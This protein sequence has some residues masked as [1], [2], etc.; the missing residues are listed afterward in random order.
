[1]NSAHPKPVEADPIRAH[2]EMLHDRAA[3]LNGVLVVSVFNAAL[4]KDAGVITH[5]KIGDVDGMVAA[6]KAH[7]D[8]PHMNI[9]C[10]CQVMRPDLGRGKRGK[11]SDVVAVLGL[12]A[13]MDNDTGK[14]AGE[15]PVAPNYVIETSPGNFQPFWLFDRPVKPDV[16]KAIALGLKAATGSDHGT[17]DIDHIWRIPG[18]LNWPNKKKLE[19]G[20]SPEPFT[21]A[22]AQPWDGALTDPA[23]M[24]LAVASRAPAS[25]ESKPATLGDLPSV[26]GIE[27]SA[28]A[29]AML[30]ADD[31]GDRSVHASSVVEQLAFD[32]HTAE[33]AA[34]LFLAATGNWLER[35]STEGAARTDF[36]RLW[37]KYGAHH[38]EERASAAAFAER[39]TKRKDPPVAANDNRPP[40]PRM[41]PAPYAAEAAGGALEALTRWITSTAIVPVPELSLAA[42]LALMGGIFGRFA[43]TPTHAGVNLYMT[44]LLSTA[45]GKAHPPKAIRAVADRVG[46]A[47]AVTNG[48]PTS[49]AAI[50]RMLRKHS[51]TVIIMDE[52]GL[53][54]QDVNA[55]HR[56]AVA[57]GIR[58]MLL[59]VYDQANSVFDGRV[60]ASSETKK[61]ESPLRGPALTVLAMST[62]ETLYAGLSEASVSDGFLNRF[63]FFAAQKPEGP[64]APPKLNRDVSPP[65]DLVDGLK[66]ALEAFPRV[67]LGASM[68]YAVPFD[69]GEEGEAYRRWGEVFT[70]QHATGSDITG[71]A[72]ENT[73]RL[74]TLRA[75]SRDAG[76]PLVNVEDV[77]WGWAITHA[78]IATIE[79]GMLTHMAASPAEALR[80]AIVAALDAAPDTTLA[81]SH[82]LHRKGVRQAE[83]RDVDAAL[84]WLVET[85]QVADLAG[86]TKPGKGSK[87]K[88]VPL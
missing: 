60:Y 8:T 33:E 30:A 9:Y 65:D 86:R 78:S 71:R 58:K 6:I 2:V 64:P 26:D 32:G 73:V 20:R 76:Q 88:L 81:Y 5:H 49:F 51:S 34:A 11:E 82:L 18:T 19:R 57:A 39:L 22:V 25:T 52:F 35:Y 59:A 47:G 44:T 16:A 48:D 1:M 74:A 79:A 63:L 14:N 31:V 21:V 75:I 13:D 45:G 23:E 15:Y 27:V 67:G 10:G 36:A 38:A 43:L 17:A 24:A 28:K 4:A 62:L 7:S 41:H 80:K 61:D 77:E 3:G 85:G 72:A 55:R 69:G 83:L 42:A 56:N 87:F 66:A 84:A 12:V 46:A 70:W 40:L 54:L 68:K 53:T 37:A 50:E 29:A